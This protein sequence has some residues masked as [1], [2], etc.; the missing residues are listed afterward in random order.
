IGPQHLFNKKRLAHH[1]RDY[2]PAVEAPAQVRTAA[3]MGV[4]A[5]G[6]TNPAGCDTASF[7]GLTEADIEAILSQ[8]AGGR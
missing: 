3:S 1:I 7:H 6:A 4:A 2:E 5:C 8:M